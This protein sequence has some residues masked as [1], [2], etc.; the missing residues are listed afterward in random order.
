MRGNVERRN[1]QGRGEGVLDGG[2]DVR[3]KKTVVDGVWVSFESIEAHTEVERGVGDSAVVNMEDN[4]DFDGRSSR[5]G[6]RICQANDRTRVSSAV[7]D[8]RSRDKRESVVLKKVGG[9]INHHSES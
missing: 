6:L 2:S 1:V 9:E 7:A 3:N 5:N 8:V 4:V